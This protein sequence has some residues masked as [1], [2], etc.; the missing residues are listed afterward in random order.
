MTQSASAHLAPHSQ[1]VGCAQGPRRR[2]RALAK[3]AKPLS[4]GRAGALRGACTRD[5]A[6]LNHSCASQGSCQQAP[7]T[8]FVPLHLWDSLLFASILCY[9]KTADQE[10]DRWDSGPCPPSRLPCDPLSVP[11]L[12]TCPGWKKSQD[13][14][15]GS[16]T[17][18]AVT[19]GPP[20]QHVGPRLLS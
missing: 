6:P 4:W 19:V 2:W 14:P 15:G 17:P 5:P 7:P 8:P 10:P 3:Q 9:G 1:A 16:S 18:G 13:S 11:C 12:W 20:L